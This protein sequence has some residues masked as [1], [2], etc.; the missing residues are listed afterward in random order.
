MDKISIVVP[1]Y[2]K[3]KYIENCLTSLLLQN[4]KNIEIIVIDDGSTDS[5]S[6]IC[7]SLIQNTSK[8]IYKK[9]KNKG[10]SSARNEG[11]ELATGKYITFVDAD[12][13]VYKNIYVDMIDKINEDSSDLV[14]CGIEIETEKRK[15]T[16]KNLKND[17]F[18]NA[19]EIINSPWNKIFKLDIIKENNLKFKEDSHWA[20]DLNFIFKYVV[21]SKKISFINKILYR[22]CKNI[23]SVTLSLP[24]Y[25][26]ID[27][28]YA[29]FYDLKIFLSN[30]K[31]N[32]NFYNHSYYENEYKKLVKQYF[33]NGMFILICNLYN[34]KNKLKT[35]NELEKFKEKLYELDSEVYEDFIKNRK[36]YYLRYILHSK[37][38]GLLNIYLKIRIKLYFNKFN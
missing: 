35:E 1:L 18:E 5:S 7:F 8:I 30:K 32:S 13:S 10:C 17:L 26:R 22:Y 31:E 38:K 27:E 24:N 37:F 19:P 6:D 16:I 11:I 15:Y 23:D 12:D 28:A 21:L 20:E 34:S 4:Y 29:V 25:S 2:N 9:T 36:E 14:V 3:E 33:C